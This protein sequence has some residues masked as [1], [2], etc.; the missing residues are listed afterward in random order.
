MNFIELTN[1]FE[2]L[3]KLSARNEMVVVTAELLRGL[4]RADVA[5]TIYMM[6]GRV[7]PL[8]VA[9]EFGLSSKMLLRGIALSSGVDV[10]AV[11]KVYK[12]TGDIGLTA[13]QLHTG[14]SQGLGISDVS[15]QL[16]AIA[17]ISG[18][19]SQTHKLEGFKQLAEQLSAQELKF[20]ARIIVGKM[21][22]G[23]SSKTYVESLSWALAGDKSLKASIERAYGISADLGVLGQRLLEDGAQVLDN[24]S[25]IPGVPIASKLVQREKNS[26][27]LFERLGPCYIQPKYDGLRAQIHY[28]KSGFLDD[29]SQTVRV[30]SRNME[31]MTFM[32]P[33][34]AA[35]VA[36]LGVD[37]LVLDSEA[38][39]F[40]PVTG[41]LTAFQTTMMRK[42]KSDIEEYAK[43]IPLR[44]FAF[45]LLFIDGK[46]LSQQK[47]EQRIEQ[48]AKL[49]QGQEK[50]NIVKAET[51]L[52]S[53]AEELE[54]KFRAHVA[55]G[56]EGLI[57]KAPGTIYEPGTRNYDWIKL[58]AASDSSLADTVDAVVLGYYAGRGDRARFGIGA[59]LI[60]TYDP[61]AEKYLS[62]TKVGTGITDELWRQ[63]KPRLDQVKVDTLPTNVL[64]DKAL[65]P[66]V[67]VR[68]E[69][70]VVV[71]ADEI[72][73]S[74][75]HGSGQEAEGFSL[76]F[77]RLKVFD[78][79]DKSALQIT[80]LQELQTLYELAH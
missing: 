7:A 11:E 44:V 47:L 39:G 31:D 56:L 63:I 59:F 15:E 68:P 9:L 45:D 12:A 23:L 79:S 1:Y 8:Y 78:R 69:V 67:L 73:K 35:N 2:K 17:K 20:V 25:V 37:S 38:I 71:E 40:D 48:L 41:E 28:S 34:V 76:R 6:Q 61:K 75:V 58:K 29:P 70:V 26:T 60:G 50:H 10:E 65:L 57:A 16:I 52:V 36:A 77:P 21:R 46:D 24:L 14:K 27:S 62:L 5:C 72:S 49:L 30:F 18:K 32:L 13:E 55:E 54:A 53:T 43:A 22:F 66:D 4:D 64:I 80:T 19:D 74:K 42:R 51:V 33:D 3:E